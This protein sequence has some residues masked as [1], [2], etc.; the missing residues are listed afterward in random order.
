MTHM[1]GLGVSLFSTGLSHPRAARASESWA[2][3][4]T[5]RPFA[6]LAGDAADVGRGVIGDDFGG[7]SAGLAAKGVGKGGA[8]LQQGRKAVIV[9]VCIDGIIGT[10]ADK[11][12]LGGEM[13]TGFGGQEF[14]TAARRSETK[15]VD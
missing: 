13:I 4:R 11:V 14:C 9:G 2:R 6:D 3:H 5:G 12:A 10:A 1:A 15:W 8:L 7:E